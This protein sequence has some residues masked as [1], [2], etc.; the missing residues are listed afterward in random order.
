MRVILVLLCILLPGFTT[1]GAASTP[2]PAPPMG[3]NSWDA[4]G[5]TID[6]ADF[7][8]TA[9]QLAKLRSSAWSYAIIDEGWYMANPSGDNL[10]NRQYILDGHGLLAPA[11]ARFPS[12]TDDRGFEPLGKWVHAHGL[13][14]GLHIV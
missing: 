9:G 7:K 3:W 5:L 14:F 11:P 6:E 8:A 2:A 1:T 10:A 4:F 12:A 13:K